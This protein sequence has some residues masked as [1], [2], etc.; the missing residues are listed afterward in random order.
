MTAD[1]LVPAIPSDHGLSGAGSAYSLPA[2]T[3]H[4]CV[5]TSGDTPFRASGGVYGGRKKM[6]WLTPPSPCRSTSC[7][8]ST[9][10][11]ISLGGK[12]PGMADDPNNTRLMSSLPPYPSRQAIA[13]RSHTTNRLPSSSVVP[14]YSRRPLRCSTAS[15]LIRSGVRTAS[16]FFASGALSASA[17]ANRPRTGRLMKMSRGRMSV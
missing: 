2:T 7:R 15:S 6:P 5:P 8:P 10:T 4:T 13:P 12:K 11:G 1:T 9:V 14:T 16:I 17:S 3:H